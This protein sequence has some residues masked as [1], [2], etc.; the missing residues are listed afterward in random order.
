MSR[1]RDDVTATRPATLAMAGIS[2]HSRGVA[3]LTDVSVE[4]PARRGAR[5]PRRER[6][7]QVDAD[8]HRH[9]DAVSPTAARSPSAGE[10]VHGAQPAGG[11]RRS[12]IAIVHQH[13]AVLPDLTVLENLAG[14]PAGRGVPAEVAGAEVAARLLDA[15]RPAGRPPGPGRDADRR[16][17]APARDRQG[18]RGLAPSC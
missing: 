9:R 13:P 12:G 14:R 11:D 16:P 8:E 10:T 17:A 18:L 1:D 2:K 15:G 6:R 4:R 3:A 7:G 5:D